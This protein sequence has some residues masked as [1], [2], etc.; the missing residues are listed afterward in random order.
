[1]VVLIKGLHQDLVARVGDNTFVT[2]MIVPF[3]M[4]VDDLQSASK[5]Q[6]S[7]NDFKTN[8]FKSVYVN[9]SNMVYKTTYNSSERVVTPK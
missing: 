1:M 5:K 8:T 7:R 9:V 6:L 3:D 2:E 4:P